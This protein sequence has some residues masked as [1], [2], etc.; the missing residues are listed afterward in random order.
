VTELPLA[1]QSADFGFT[2]EGRAET[3]EGQ[4]PHADI[5]NV[6]HDYFHAMRIPLLNGRDLTEAEVRD[7][8]MVAV[9]SQALAQRFFAGE[10]PVGQRLRPNWMTKGFYEIVGVVGDVRHRGLEGDLVQTIYL[11]SLRLGYTNLVIRTTNNPISLAAAVRKEV[12]AI[13]PH[14]PVANIK[15]MEQWVSSSVAEPRFRT[16][17]LGLFSAV[18]LL[19]SV[20][21][22]Y[23]VLSYAVTQRTHDLGIRMALGARAGDVLGMVIRQG[24]KL[25]FAGIAIGLAA[26]FA[27]TRLMQELLFGVQATDPMTFAA[28]ALLL[29][30]IALLACYLPARRAAQVDPMIALRHE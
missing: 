30:I 6:N 20:V 7:N 23:G 18:A 16:L 12:A 9:I 8:A 15:T 21:G 11:P 5:R 10:D 29:A 22:I 4:G 27:L 13:D 1:R 25:A 14:Q 17:L 3:P 26:A 19:L 24:M 28:I 2:I